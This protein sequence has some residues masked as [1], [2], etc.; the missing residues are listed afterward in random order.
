MRLLIDLHAT[1][2]AL[3]YSHSKTV[4]ENENVKGKERERKRGRKRGRKREKAQYLLR[5]LK[6]IFLTVQYIIND[7]IFTYPYNIMTF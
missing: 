7:E 6:S 4:K 5:V 1:F 2:Y 3:L